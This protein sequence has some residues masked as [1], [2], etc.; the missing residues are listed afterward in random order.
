[1]KKL[2]FV[3]LIFSTLMT[4]GLYLYK[5][6]HKKTE[7][8]YGPQGGPVAPVQPVSPIQPPVGPKTYTFDEAVAL[9]NKAD[10]TEWLTYL[11][12]DELEG[13]MTGK[14][15]NKLAAD[16]AK[17]KFEGWGYKTELQKFNV[18]QVNPGPKNETGD[19][20]TQ[21]VIAYKPGQTDYW[22]IVG[23][24]LDHVGYGPAMALDQGI[25]IHPGADDNGSG[26]TGV[27]LTAQAM[28]KLPPLRHGII[29]VLFSGEEMGLLGSKHYVSQ[30]GAEKLKKIDLMVNY[31]MI[32]RLKENGYVE[33]VGARKSA[34]VTS[35]LQKLDA[36][37]PPVKTL[38][39]KTGDGQGNSDHAPFYDRGVPVCFFFTGM[40]PQYHRATDK[41][42]LINFD[43]L[44]AVA[45]TGMDL[46]YQY[47]QQVL[48][49]NSNRK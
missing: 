9:I 15:G 22:I 34:T 4:G 12:S 19:D 35:L 47:D 16:F 42:G 28:S 8:K 17:K 6:S 37:Y 36:K 30:L 49:L 27:L 46:V 5:Q 18:R 1:M 40:H 24:H 43:G 25:A 38:D 20:F 48:G 21:N 11:T 29:F 3:A 26:T 14:A 33:C 13:R 45:K 39:P 44:I 10:A 31:D 32:G 2:L 23:A 7:S 41:V